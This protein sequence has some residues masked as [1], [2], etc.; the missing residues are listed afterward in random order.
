MK[1]LKKRGL[2][3]AIALILL[4]GMAIVFTYAWYTRITSVSALDFHL[5]RW[6]FNANYQTQE[7]LVN[8]YEYTHVYDNPDDDVDLAAPG[9]AGTINVRLGADEADVDIEYMIM[10]DK[11]TLSEEF[12]K[13]LYF[14][15]RDENDNRIEF[16]GF[17]NGLPGTIDAHSSAIASFEWEWIYDYDEYLGINDKK[18]K[19]AVDILKPIHETELGSMFTADEFVTLYNERAAALTGSSA[20]SFEEYYNA[21]ADVNADLYRLIDGLGAPK[22]TLFFKVMDNPD[23]E[24]GSSASD[25][26]ATLAGGSFTVEGDTYSSP[27]NFLQQYLLGELH[28]ASFREYYQAYETEFKLYDKFDTQVGANPLYYATE[29]AAKIYILGA[30]I[31]PELVSRS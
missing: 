4:I 16:D 24:V 9:T 20:F 31:Q 23:L 29:M 18:Q 22:R 1:D 7:I 8:V 2:L 26:L 28:Y 11:S 3:V 5:A 6:D 17:N 10:L 21:A 15:Y 12:Q 27:E 13:R 25:P 19:K 30:Q 14:Y